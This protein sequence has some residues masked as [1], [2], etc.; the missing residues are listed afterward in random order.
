MSEKKVT[1]Y[2]LWA[3][4][5]PE[6]MATFRNV[7]KTISRKPRKI[8]FILCDVAFD[9]PY[10]IR[11]VLLLYRTGRKPSYYMNTTYYGTGKSH[12]K[13][14]YCRFYDKN[15]QLREVKKKNMVSELL[16]VEMV[17]RPDSYDRFSM[18]EL[19]NAPLGFNILIH[20]IH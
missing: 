14:G 7:F 13:N 4:T 6:Y 20:F 11:K 8:N 15:K 16:R 3:E 18:R 5:N 10:V 2:T 12:K 17:Y 1:Y 19:L 9:I